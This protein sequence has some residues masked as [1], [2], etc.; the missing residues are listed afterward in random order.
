MS[1]TYSGESLQFGLYLL[2][3]P[4]RPYRALLLQVYPDLSRSLFR[5]GFSQETAVA[6]LPVRFATPKSTI[7][8]VRC[9][10]GV[11]ISRCIGTTA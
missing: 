9:Y 10:Q 11:R 7:S 4:I 6:F 2:T 3:Q 1:W 5:Q 8:R